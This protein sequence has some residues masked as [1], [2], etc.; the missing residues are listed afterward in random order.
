MKEL[1]MVCNA[2]LDPVWLWDWEEGIAAALSTFRIAARFCREYDGFIFNH[3]EA[4][5]YQWIEEYEPDLFQTIQEL[6]KEGKWH[7]MG[8]W[9]LQPDCNMPSGES[10]IRQIEAGR[11]YFYEKFG[12]LPKTAVNFDPFGHSRGLV[13]I[14]KKTGYDSYIFCR[15]SQED[16]CLP[17]DDFLWIG[18]DGSRIKGHRSSE[19]YNSLMG[20]AGK[21][22]TEFLESHQEQE[23]GLLLWGVGNHG[24]GPSHADMAQILEK[25]KESPLCELRHSIPE[26]Y[27]HKIENKN[28]PE[29]HRDLNPWAVGCYTAQIRIK[30][31]HRKLEGLLYMTEKMVSAAA[32]RKKMNYP[33]EE[34][35]EAEKALLTA[36]FHDILP[37]SAVKSVEESGIRIMNYGMELLEKQKNR[38]FFALAEGEKPAGKG[39]YPILIYNPHPYPVKGV[40][41]CEFQMQNQNWDT[42]FG[43][44][45]VFY[46]GEPIPCQVE[47]EAC[48]MNL[49]WRKKVVFYGEL[50]PM[51]MNRFDCTITFIEKQ[52]NKDLL[53]E[54][55]EIYFT[56]EHVEAVISKKTGLMDSLKIDGTEYL[57]EGAFGL[58]VRDSGFDPWAMNV[59]SFPKEEGRFRLMD[60]EE[61]TDFSGVDE[62]L[63]SVRIIETGQVRTIVEALFRYH[64]SRAVIHY[65][66][67]KKGW[68]VELELSVEWMEKGKMLKLEIPTCLRGQNLCETAYGVQTYES[69]ERERVMQ[70]WC[71]IFEE[72]RDMAMTCINDGCYGGDFQDGTMGISLIHA[73]AY[74]A[75]PIEDR[76]LLDQDRRI[77]CMDQGE[78]SFSFRLCGGSYKKRM[79][80]VTSE[81]VVFQEKPLA[82]AFFP[83]EKA[84]VKKKW[85]SIS[86]P[87]CILGAMKKIRGKDTYLIRLFESTGTAREVSICLWDEVNIKVWLGPCEIKTLELDPETCRLIKCSMIPSIRGIADI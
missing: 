45:E 39:E 60:K 27:F 72:E 18:F 42:S 73:A 57:K 1:H 81:A 46:K 80:N 38:A 21:K 54:S 84:A 48:N 2:H 58:S 65:I 59:Q 82:V 13:Q 40:M 75:H 19:H 26:S 4:L 79:E 24:G 41:T 25:R 5:L 69:S 56:G 53:K 6:V 63:E 30:Q 32:F 43:M 49:D 23:E 55:G 12:V 28:L 34:M 71:G 86:D 76:V 87:G 7:I 29:F 31:M 61:G 66:L 44:P 14:L 83:T 3:N 8:G 78:R 68:D 77:P 70:R 33:E 15:P 51:Q 74:S 67:P 85:I 47:K 64:N 37:G 52:P 17:D 50:K 20:E 36:Q 35:K 62:E 16:C 22:I 11:E 9:F 10:F